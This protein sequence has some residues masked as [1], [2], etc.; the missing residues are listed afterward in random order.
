MPLNAKIGGPARY[1][2]DREAT[3][4]TNVHARH[5]YKTA[6]SEYIVNIDTIKQEIEGEN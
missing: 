6:E 5:I 1:I 2:A 4:L 3:C